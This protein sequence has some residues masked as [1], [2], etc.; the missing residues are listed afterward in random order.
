MTPIM[1][2]GITEAGAGINGISWNI[3]GQTY[4]PKAH[5]DSSLSWHATFPPGAFL[6]PHIHPTQDE[7]IYLLEGR[8]DVEFDGTDTC[9]G[10]GATLRMPRG[11]AHGLYN[12][13]DYAVKCFFWVT[14]ARRLYDLFWELHNLGPDADPARVVAVAAQHE[15]DFLPPPEPG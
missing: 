2:A 1:T 15:V 7:F 11:L 4:V 3:L 9:A 5:T 14:P 12:R 8:L 6:P 13:S 10:P